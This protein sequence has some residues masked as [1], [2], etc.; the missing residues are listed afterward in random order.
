MNPALVDEDLSVPIVLIHYDGSET[1]TRGTVARYAQSEGQL[2][3]AF[4][5]SA[6]N[7]FV[8][9]PASDVA[10]SHVRVTDPGTG[11]AAVYRALDAEPLA[12]ALWATGALLG[13]TTRYQLLEHAGDIPASAI[14]TLFDFDPADFAAADFN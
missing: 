10:V 13:E 7:A 8:P 5:R 11:V 9:S 12:G 1:S 3:G 14:G 2:D 6:R 4:S